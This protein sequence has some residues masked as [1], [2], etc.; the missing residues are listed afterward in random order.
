[1]T[2]KTLKAMEKAPLSARIRRAAMIRRIVLDDPGLESRLR[3]GLESAEK[4]LLAHAESADDPRIS[5][6][7]GHLAAAGGKRLRPLLALLGAEFGDPWRHGVT[8]AAV[9]AELVHVSSLYH[10]DV[11]DNATTRHGVP[12]VNAHWGDRLAVLAG[13]LLLAK[14][15]RLAADLGPEAAT[16]NANVAG[17]L[18]AGQIYEL[19]GP[20]PGEDAI[21]H[22]FQV[23]AGKTAALLGMALRLGAQQAGAP[24]PVVQGL[25]EY[26]EELGLAFQIADD[27]L[28]LKASTEQLGK[29]MGKDLAAGIA[30]LPVLLALADTTPQGAALREL[31]SAGP[32]AGPAEQRRALKLFRRSPALGEAEAIMHDRLGRARRALS[33]LPPSPALQAL[34]ALCDFV[35]DQTR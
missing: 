21:D 24:D 5:R 31:L 30:S 4:E 3:N 29:E 23:I 10:D 34:N 11:M 17:R 2:R 18:V 16:L 7:I 25:G 28:D 13:D 33:E 6:L 8:Q 9:I 20:A 15:A 26:G 1:M 35:A 27:L 22:Y 32:T 12:S 19:A 14:A